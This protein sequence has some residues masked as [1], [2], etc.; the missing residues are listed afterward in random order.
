MRTIN[1]I[2]V[3]LVFALCM[4]TCLCAIAKPVSSFPAIEVL[5]QNL[6]GEYESKLKITDKKISDIKKSITESNMSKLE[7]KMKLGEVENSRNRI[8]SLID[9]IKKTTGSIAQT[10]YDAL[11]KEFELN[12]QLID[13][14]SALLK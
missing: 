8:H 4:V 12:Q 13:Q 5:Q 10:D 2:L 3:P 14:L 9:Q 1:K 6:L 11:Q 7:I